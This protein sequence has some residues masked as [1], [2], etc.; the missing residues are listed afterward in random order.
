MRSA[1]F[2]GKTNIELLSC[3]Y[4]CKRV[5]RAKGSSSR[6][7]KARR[8]V[9]SSASSTP[10]LDFDH[11]TWNSSSPVSSPATEEMDD[12]L[13]VKSEE[14]EAEGFASNEPE[15]QEW[16]RRDNE[17]EFSY[18]NTVEP[19]EPEHSAPIYHPI[20]TTIS[21]FSPL[22]HSQFP[23][24]FPKIVPPS[25]SYH[26]CLPAHFSNTLH[27]LDTLTLPIYGAKDTIDSPV[28]NFSQGGF[29]NITPFGR[30]ELSDDHVLRAGWGGIPRARIA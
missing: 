24:A 19:P 6:A 13:P 4:G 28:H 15:T 17:S 20:A 21:L 12:L 3:D 27:V 1:R 11:A 2:E 22:A 23:I 9:S 5:K 14:S 7:T 30:L 29:A 18:F 26:P 25:P 16:N 10:S 8:R